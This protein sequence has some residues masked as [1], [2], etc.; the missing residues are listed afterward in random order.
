[1]CAFWM[2]GTTLAFSLS[3]MLTSSPFIS[4]TGSN[5][6]KKSVS[7]PCVGGRPLWPLIRCILSSS[8]SKT[9]IQTSDFSGKSVPANEFRQ[10]FGAFLGT[11]CEECNTRR[12]VPTS[13][14]VDATY[15]YWNI[16]CIQENAFLMK[17]LSSG[18]CR[19]LILAAHSEHAGR[20]RE[21]ASRRFH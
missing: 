9:Q 16:C 11:L 17:L 21:R 4:T 10:S 2:D 15:P 3:S 6:S 18:E 1:M 12:D 14:L 5:W 8:P 19:D 20:R 13:R 7:I